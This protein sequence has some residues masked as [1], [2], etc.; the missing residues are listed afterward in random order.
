MKRIFGQIGKLKADKI[1]EYVNLHRNPWPE[2]LDMI[3]KCNL[4]NY[5]IFVEGDYAFSYFEY[6]GSDYDEDMHM[7]EQD[8]MTKKWWEHTRPCFEKYAFSPESEFY[9]DMRQIFYTK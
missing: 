5:S 6:T 3:R 4:R 7:M 8:E 1:E 9:Q 2:V